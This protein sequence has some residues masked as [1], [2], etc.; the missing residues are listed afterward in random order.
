MRNESLIN[1]NGYLHKANQ[2]YAAVCNDVQKISRQSQLLNKNLLKDQKDTEGKNLTKSTLLAN[3]VHDI[4]TPVNAIKG[5]ADLL[6]TPDISEENKV[7]YAQIIRQSADNLLDLVYDLLDVSKI[8]AG[9]LSIVNRP[10]NLKDLFNE[11]FELFNNPMLRQRSGQVQLKPYIELTQGQCLIDTDFIRL[12]QILVNLISNALKFT[13]KGHVIYGCCLIDP[14][15]LCFSV[16]DT[17]IGIAPEKLGLIFDQFY[18]LNDP[19]ST[20]KCKGT[21]LGLSIVKS[22][23]GLMD[24]E[25]WVDSTKGI[26]STFYFTLP[27]KK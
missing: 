5:F 11:L 8:E 16:E 10:G 3:V 17:G 22:L 27:F 9:E 25:L 23:V 26:G 20:N 1:Q 15:T 7:K 6:L 14:D 24:G 19:G 2:L 13:E 12:R 4:C 21:G 18:Q